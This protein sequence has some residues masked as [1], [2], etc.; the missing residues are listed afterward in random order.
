M[1]VMVGLKC[2]FRIHLIFTFTLIV[3]ELL[4][5]T[6]L[7]KKCGPVVFI[8]VIPVCFGVV[9][10]TFIPKHQQYK[11]ACIFQQRFTSFV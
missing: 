6:S 1:D 7:S 2:L 5:S 10:F 9:L 4:P 8:S 11:Y 3:S